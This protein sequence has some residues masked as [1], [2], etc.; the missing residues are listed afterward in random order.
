[1]AGARR[2]MAWHPLSALVDALAAA[3][4]AATRTPR[5][6]VYSQPRTA[7][8]AGATCSRHHPRPRTPAGAAILHPRGALVPGSHDPLR[9][10]PGESVDRRVAIDRGRPGSLLRG[11][12]RAH[13][14][15]AFWDRSPVQPPEPSHRAGGY[16]SSWHF[17]PLLSLRRAQPPAKESADVATRLRRRAAARTGGDAG[18]GR[19]WSRSGLERSGARAAVHT[20]GR[21][22]GALRGR[23]G[24]NAALAVRRLWLSGAGGDGLRHGGDRLDRRRAPRNCWHRRDSAEPR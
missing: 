1:M 17:R 21:A 4:G 7:G 14:G 6:D 20:G 5:R 22:A 10:P 15:G 2:G 9:R 12:G 13:R 19:T 23:A 16:P 8:R 11:A 18:A 3:T 24:P